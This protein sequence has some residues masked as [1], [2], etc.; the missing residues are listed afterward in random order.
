MKEKSK[1]ILG[2]FFKSLISND[3]AIEG[4]KKS[5]WWM[6]LIMFVLSIGLPLIPVSVNA[7][8]VNGSASLG[9]YT[10]GSDTR[11]AAVLL[12]A[13]QMGYEFNIENGECKATKNGVEVLNTTDA[14]AY[15]PLVRY[16][17]Q[18]Q[19]TVV[20]AD[21]TKTTSE[22][23]NQFD[24]DLY[25]TA[26][27]YSSK[28]EL[29]VEDMTKKLN[30]TVYTLGTKNVRPAIDPEED[31][32][33]AGYI[34]SYV[35]IHKTGLYTAIYQ[36]D[37]TVL[38]CY[39]SFRADWKHTKPCELITRLLDVKDMEAADKKATNPE[40]VAGVYKNYKSV[41]S[42]TY[43]TEKSSNLV[44]SVLI[45]GGVY[46]ALLAMMGFMLWLLTRGKNNPFNYL[47]FI[48]TSRIAAWAGLAPAIL[49]MILG[50]MITNYAPFIFIIL[51][52]LRTMWLAMK[53]LK[54]Y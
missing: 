50:F 12:E 22:I 39:T 52:G 24:L 5:P 2:S 9:Q 18:R 11:L 15:T 33:P 48:T 7:S 23:V 34:P 47:S 29:S 20:N 27:P 51:L 38:Y 4:A 19:N 37:S 42:E 16:E 31:E 32:V 41:V 44:K 26:R 8:R 30:E 46:I 3:A 28:D 10:L 17:S 45:Y 49:G 35:I 1:F 53:Q 14:D 54:P 43:L 13:Q 6:A 36:Q 21:G 25:F 40:F